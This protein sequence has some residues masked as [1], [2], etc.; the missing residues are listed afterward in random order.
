M[1]EFSFLGEF[2]LEGYILYDAEGITE[3]NKFSLYLLEQLPFQ[4]S[5]YDSLKCSLSRESQMFVINE[6]VTQQFMKGL[7]EF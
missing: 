7:A 4:E 5:T 1:A 6:S 2:T 3:G